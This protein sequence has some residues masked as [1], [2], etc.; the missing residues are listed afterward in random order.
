MSLTI[1]VTLDDEAVAR[2]LDLY[3]EDAGKEITADMLNQNTD[4][5][6]AMA[7]DML[8]FWFED[9]THSPIH[10]SAYDLYNEFFSKNELD[11]EEV[12]DDYD[13]CAHLGEDMEY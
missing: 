12:E 5:Q 10:A 7:D 1:T 3:N 4:L 6:N 2:F 9:I 11:D 8:S 13:P